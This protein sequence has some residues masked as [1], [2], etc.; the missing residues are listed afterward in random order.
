VTPKQSVERF[1]EAFNDGDLDGFGSVLHPEVEIAS[2]RGLREGIEEA[3][4][5][6]TRTPGGM[7]VQR[8]IVDELHEQGTHV[9]ALITR[10]WSWEE[11]DGGDVAETE[12]L[13][14]L[15]TFRDGKIARVQ[16]FEERGEAL[17]AAGIEA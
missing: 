17:A 4:Q 6:A 1:Y 16:P 13:G 9:V 2:A 3:K 8:V 14:T 7:L 10:Q 12:E 5:W 15:F 11:G